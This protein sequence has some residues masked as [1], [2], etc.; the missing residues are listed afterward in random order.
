MAGPVGR[1]HQ[2]HGLT[3]TDA[4]PEPTAPHK[5][6][7]WLLVQIV[8]LLR[9]P[10]SIAMVSVLL[11]NEQTV[12]V[13]VI[14]SVLLAAIEI[15]D[16]SDGFLARRYGLV[17]Q[18]GAML[19]PYSDSFA[20]LIVYWGFAQGGLVEQFVP[21]V[22]ALRDVTV[23]YCRIVL[24]QRGGSVSARLTGKIKAWVQG[25]GA[26]FAILQP[27]FW[28]LGLGKWS[29]ALVSWIVAVATVASVYSYASAA[30]AITRGERADG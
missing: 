3:M 14:C 15:S 2:E 20:R 25:V 30:I 4:A 12:T 7:G 22:M 17:S 21:L 26:G 5:K 6:P 10:L 13:I 18:W 29:V 1:P 16:L 28:Y 9:I 19:D 23:S 11:L 27:G 24:T 8:T